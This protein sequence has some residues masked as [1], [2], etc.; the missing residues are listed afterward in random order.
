MIE[1]SEKPGVFV[2]LLVLLA[3]FYNA[4]LA[5]INAHVLDLNFTSVAITELA[6]LLVLLLLI[7]RR[8]I[9]EEDLAP[10]IYLIITIFLAVYVS[11]INKQI[12]PDYIRNILIIFCFVTIGSW[13]SFSTINLVFKSV[14]V[15]IFLVLLMEIF[16]VDQ[17]GDLFYPAKYFANTR[18]VELFT[19]VD[20]KLFRNALGFE[21]RFTFGIIGHRSSSL[22]LEQVSLANFSGVMM[23]YLLT[24]WKRF[25]PFERLFYVST[26]TL[27]LLTND[28]RTMLIFAL[29][30][31][32]GYFI[33]PLLPRLFSL[34]VMPFILLMGV[35]VFI[36]KPDAT[37]DNIPG[38]VVFTMRKF[39]D[40]DWPTQLGFSAEIASSLGDS[41]YI[42]V[43]VI[44][45][46]FSLV[47]LW[48]FV[49]LYPACDTPEE[50]RFIHSLSVFVFMNMMIGGTAVFS[51]K[52][53]ALLWL[54]AGHMK[55][56]DRKASADNIKPTYARAQ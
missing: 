25:S 29:I 8:G 38:R 10:L 45:T 14:S 7:I 19:V 22:F 52:I 33:F 54:L 48:L 32:I 39:A 2:A 49:G 47:F 46:I 6:T 13:C 20:S 42:Y 9:Y 27:I 15:L 37:G 11:V 56:P 4:A 35:L 12:Y 17:Y 28:T 55:F 26:I 41:G 18:G 36:L 40:L 53:A 3:T 1:N 44:G 43:V 21:G 16:F 23:I 24:L 34:L 30:S 51:I 31:F 5:V 50:R